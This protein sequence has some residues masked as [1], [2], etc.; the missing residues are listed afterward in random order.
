MSCVISIASAIASEVAAPGP[1]FQHRARGEFDRLDPLAR[2]DAL[3]QLVDLVE[4]PGIGLAFREAAGQLQRAGS[5]TTLAE[6]RIWRHVRTQR[7]I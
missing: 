1:V 4:P 2:F 6:S 3:T 5:K 7:T